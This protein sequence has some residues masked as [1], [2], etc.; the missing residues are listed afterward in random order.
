[1]NNS[2][3]FSNVPE[4]PMIVAFIHPIKDQIKFNPHV[5]LIKKSIFDEFILEKIYTVIYRKSFMD[6][7]E[8]QNYMVCF[9]EVFEVSV[10]QNSNLNLRIKEDPSIN[11]I[12]DIIR[13]TVNK[14]FEAM[15]EYCTELSPTLKNFNTYNSINFEKLQQ[16][17]K[18]EE[19]KDF[20]E[21]FAKEGVEIAKIRNKKI[22]GVFEFNLENL[23][24]MVQNA[25]ALWLS[26]MR[27]LIPKLLINKLRSLIQTLN[28]YIKRLSIQ[29]IDPETFINLKQSVKEI[30][31][32]K[33]KIDHKNN[34]II[35]IINII[36]D[37]PE[38]K[39]PEYDYKMIREKESL[40]VEFEKKLDNMVYY[41]ET[42]LSKY[43]SDLN[44]NIRNFAKEIDEMKDQLNVDN[45]NIY[46]EDNYSAIFYIEDKSVPIR[47]LLDKKE[48]FIT[49]ENLIEI[50]ENSNF[51]N[52]EDLVYE[53]ELKSK[54]WYSVR[55]FQSMSKKWENCQ[56][57]QVNLSEMEENILKWSE[58]GE[59]AKQDL[60]SQNVPN[61]LLDNIKN[62]K[63]ILPILKTF[64]NPNINE[65]KFID[66][67]KKE[68]DVEFNFDYA[69]FTVKRLI[70]IPDVLEKIDDIKEI[71][72]MAD[73]ENRIKQIYEKVLE[74][75]LNHKLPRSKYTNSKQQGDK[76]AERYAISDSDFQ[77][78][79][80]YIEEKLVVLKQLLLNPYSEPLQKN[81][82]TL[83]NNFNKYLNFL[84]EF[85]QYQKFINA[86]E[87]VVFLNPEFPKDMP[88]EYKKIN[89]ENALKNCSKLLKENSA[90]G[91]YID[92]A[93]DKV[94]NDLRRGNKNYEEL[95]KFIEEYLDK[96]R[97]E[98][99]KYYYLSNEELLELYQKTDDMEVKRRH[100]SKM[101]SGIKNVDLGSDTDENIKLITDDDEVIVFKFSK[102]KGN[103]REILDAV[104]AEIAKKL[105]NSF[106]TYKRDFAA[107]SK[108]SNN[109]KPKD[110]IIELVKNHE[111]LGQAIFNFV[112]SYYMEQLEKALNQEDAFDKIMDFRED[113]K[114]RK[115]SFANALKDLNSSKV[116][117]RIIMNLIS[118]ESYIKNIIKTLV[119][120]DVVST[121]D[122]NWLKYLHIK[123]D[124]ENCNLRV[125]NME[126]EYGY[127]YVGLQNNFIVSPFTERIYI[128]FANCV[129]E[130][131]PFLLYG[132]PESGK[133]E[134]LH[135]FAKIL[136]KSLLIFKCSKDFDQKAFHKVLYGGL[137]TSGNWL[138]LDNI[139]LVS[140]ENLSTIAQ[141]IL[142]VHWN[143]LDLKADFYLPYDKIPINR[144]TQ[145]I[146]TTRLSK[147]RN[148]NI[149][150]E[151]VKYSFRLIG[152][153]VPNLFFI[154]HSSLKNLAFPKCKY[155]ARKIKYLLE[156]LNTK[157]SLLKYK[158]IGMNLFSKLLK[159]LERDV[160]RV[161][162]GNA[163][164]I[165]RRAIE[166]IFVPF[167]T[168]DE[169]E[170]MLVINIFY[171]KI[172]FISLII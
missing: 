14:C 88:N 148:A 116:E 26:T 71:T 124:G 17:A 3:F 155:Y 6:P 150:S 82:T 24:E 64:Q 63:Q 29:V 67:I 171:F 35:D 126:F 32:N 54:L 51:E 127:E 45:L 25:P 55:E 46:N 28:S 15:E 168:D 149:L 172:L 72:L 147:L 167:M 31:E 139:E 48:I 129:D 84:D 59:T 90:L 85:C 66:M 113:A 80:E 108:G 97:K 158:R 102:G 99:L 56:V 111:N 146:C 11:D 89:N 101:L 39:I 38:I 103:I 115:D 18:P 110:M 120:E 81:I 62:F 104:E 87:P 144:N 83:V 86:T 122:F 70:D 136:G 137:K 43:K 94:I 159:R 68:L 58:V 141:D 152:Q 4:T 138:L 33:E 134:T 128:S 165:I 151:S 74:S 12:F 140:K 163:D 160:F 9:E 106:K 123:L 162:N 22:M 98:N 121:S 47:K 57:Q 65:N 109:K 49:Q 143:I 75:Y 164:N 41:V 78:E 42:N 157:I 73:E 44:T 79:Y 100:I 37:D 30:T 61:A 69:E 10:D 27:D 7:Q 114:I 1:M 166:K 112:Y 5:E 95:F 21:K 96:K 36:K 153:S 40:F 131:K 154:I 156:Y 91:K 105:K 145:I 53:Y 119:R 13:Q 92:V 77:A 8:F 52:L 142:Q 125:F 19:L 130:K 93:H 60:E 50:E 107:N 2:T 76:N 170:D 20:L 23:I 118:L 34:E 16:D 132:L 161:N 133:K 135:S 117:K 169:N